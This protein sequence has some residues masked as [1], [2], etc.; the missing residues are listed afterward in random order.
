MNG[1]ITILFVILLLGLI[2]C[3]FLGGSGCAE[4]FTSSSGEVVA[5]QFNNGT[6]I[7][8]MPT[9]GA[10]IMK[11]NGDKT[12]I[13]DDGTTA[14]QGDDDSLTI[15]TSDGTQ[16]GS[17]SV[18]TV[19]E[20]PPTDETT[21]TTTTTTTTDTTTSNNGSTST[22][23]PTL[24]DYDHYS[25]SYSTTY[26][27]PNNS[28]AKVTNIG[29]KGKLV[30]VNTDSTTYL[31]F[32][33]SSGVSGTTV[34]GPQDGTATITT[35]NDGQAAV[36]VTRPDGTVTLYTI[37]YNPNQ[38]TDSTINQYNPSSD[39]SSSGS[40]YNNAYVYTGP[41]GSSAAAVT[42]P[43]G[44]TYVGTNYDSNAY[45][46]SLPPGIPSSQIPPGQQDLYILKSQV[47]P[48]VCPVCPP[49]IVQ[50][51]ETT[52]VT[53]CPPCPPCARCPEPA[54]DCK[55][56]PNYN[57]FNPDYMPVPVLSDFSGFGM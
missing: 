37:N 55:K 25:G 17:V 47:V 18:E 29:D 54:F 23:S 51:S 42:G 44:N 45:Y 5:K 8:G 1:K 56:V 7:V 20:A 24:D 35:N 33:K 46:N 31:Y 14:T 6:L 11:P 12:W 9:G 10:I 49:T 13:S 41:G 30:I 36:K 50:S 16:Y 39:T 38:M 53:K 43:A 32:I 34:N 57:A 26:Y 27:G 22:T 15:V 2:L 28:T 48:P 21:D 3:S 40:D 19:D 4:G 52:D